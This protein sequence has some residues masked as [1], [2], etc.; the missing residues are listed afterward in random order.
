MPSGDHLEQP[1]EVA[2]QQKYISTDIPLPAGSEAQ[3]DGEQ[4]AAPAQE[5][6]EPV[7]Q[8]LDV[9]SYF[10]GQLAERDVAKFNVHQYTDV[11][12]E[13]L[14]EL[15]IC[16]QTT[17]QAYVKGE[18]FVEFDD[19]ADMCLPEPSGALAA[20]STAAWTHQVVRPDGSVFRSI[21]DLDCIILTMKRA[22][23]KKSKKAD[24]TV[25]LFEMDI[26]LKTNVVTPLHAKEEGLTL[27]KCPNNDRTRGIGARKGEGAAFNFKDKFST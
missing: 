13:L 16:H 12:F 9:S 20:L 6:T 18:V 8:K 22:E 27:V 26:D 5:P 15:K 3:A 10:R 1:L 4:A 17:C 25:H 24:T 14:E 23:M 21:S 19:P 7:V 11:S 2:A